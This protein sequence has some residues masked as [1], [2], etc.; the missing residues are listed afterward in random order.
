MPFEMLR[1]GVRFINLTF[2]K[3]LSR[4]ERGETHAFV[5]EVRYFLPSSAHMRPKK[6][7]GKYIFRCIMVYMNK[8]EVRP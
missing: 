2:R 1:V 6:K 3:K 7:L 8:E 4:Q 5:E